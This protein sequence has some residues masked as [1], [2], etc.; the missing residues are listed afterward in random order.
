M[1]TGRRESM[2]HR[3][4]LGFA[5]LDVIIAGVLLAI[6]LS[7]IFAITARSLELQKGGEIRVQAAAMLDDLLST[8]LLEG[9]LDFPK[10]HATSGAGDFPYEQFTFQVRIDDPGEGEPF[11]V[12]A[13][14]QHSTGSSF[15]CET[16]IAAKGGEEPDPER[17]PEIPIDREARYEETLGF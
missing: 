13:T 16:L 6:G 9:P 14:V 3:G 8:V 5:L 17:M 11:R 10:L 1:R 7:T 2:D 15:A 12:V 4:R